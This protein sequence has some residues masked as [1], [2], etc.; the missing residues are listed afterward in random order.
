MNEI[1]LRYT[2]TEDEVVNASRSRVFRAWHMQL[3]AVAIVGIAIINLVIAI[4]SSDLESIL[5]AILPV[6]LLG[7][8]F[9][10]LY[11][12][13]LT[14]MRV[15]KEPRYFIEQTWEFSDAG[16][17]HHTEHG[18][19]QNAWSAYAQASENA[20]FF[21]LLLGKNMIAPIPKRAFA[22]SNEQE[23]FRALLKRKLKLT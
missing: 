11:Y 23:R 22:N 3:L 21:F 14:R 5:I 18:D 20:Q 1:V 7:S 19:S 2:L 10:I 13:P 9:M 8:I 4:T 12:G 17:H 16:V 6:V 15:R